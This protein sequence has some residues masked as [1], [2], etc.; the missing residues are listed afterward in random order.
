MY[1]RIFLQT[2]QDMATTIYT[3]Y[4]LSMQLFLKLAAEGDVFKGGNDAQ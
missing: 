2:L 4:I 1:I 3:Q